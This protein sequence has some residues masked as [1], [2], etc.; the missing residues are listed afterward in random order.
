MVK[1][2]RLAFAG[3]FVLVSGGCAPDRMTAPQQPSARSLRVTE[4]GSSAQ[5]LFVVDGHILT[6]GGRDIDPDRIANV[7]IVKGTRAVEMYGDAAANGV[8]IVTTK[9]AAA[10]GGHDAVV[11]REGQI[12]IRGS[13]AITGDVLVMV[14]GRA[15]PAA[16]L[17]DIAAD[18]ILDIQVLKGAAAVQQYGDRAAE[19]VVVVRT[20]RVDDSL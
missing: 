19:G 15:V 7:E 4:H 1:V 12:R 10:R 16:T 11:Q 2:N 9:E 3:V 5:P 17:Q 20:K 18:D 13:N 6:S 14:D 8:I